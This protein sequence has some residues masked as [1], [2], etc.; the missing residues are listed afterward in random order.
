MGQADMERDSDL[1]PGGGPRLQI[2]ALSTS[3]DPGEGMHSLTCYCLLYSHFPN[4][5]LT[6]NC[7]RA[8]VC[9]W[10]V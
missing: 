5:S 3:G 9:R 8:P 2:C 4:L 7:L 1:L 10:L 6:L